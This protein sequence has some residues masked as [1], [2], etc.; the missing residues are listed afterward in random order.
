MKIPKTK[1]ARRVGVEI[2]K[3]VAE[4]VRRET[5]NVTS[6]AIVSIPEVR[7]SDDLRHANLY[8]SIHG[9]E[10]P[11]AIQTHLL[12]FLPTLRRQVAKSLCIRKI[13][14]MRFVWDETFERADKLEQLFRKI[15]EDSTST[16]SHGEDAGEEENSE[17]TDER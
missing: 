14:E 10:D 16:G 8:C 12:R 15:E 4:T 13:P 6:G 9:V 5:A 2:Q 3:I 1:R 17:E 7:V 11:Q